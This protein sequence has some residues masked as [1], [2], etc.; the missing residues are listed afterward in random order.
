M[1]TG[2]GITSCVTLSLGNGMGTVPHSSD[3]SR[4]GT[5]NVYSRNVLLLVHETMSK[6]LQGIDSTVFNEAATS[7]N[8]I[9]VQC[10][11]GKFD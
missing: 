5:A 2:A 6:R 9:C 1:V 7:T 3:E 10:V 8:F 11:S 4:Q